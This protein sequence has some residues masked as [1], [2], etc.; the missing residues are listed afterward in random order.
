VSRKERN[1]RRE[2]DLLLELLDLP[3]P[4]L[5]SLAFE[6]H[7]RRRGHELLREGFLVKAGGEKTVV[8]D[9]FE[10]RP[11][12]L[13]WSP[14]HGAYGYFSPT[15]GW[16]STDPDHPDLR[17]E[18]N[19]AAVLKA[20]LSEFEPRTATAEPFAGGFVWDA[21]NIH[22][23]HRSDATSVWLARRVSDPTS[24]HVVRDEMVARPAVG[25]RIILTST[26]RERLPN[27][28]PPRNLLCSLRDL[29]P[30]DGNLALNPHMLAAAVIR[31]RASLRSDD[32]LAVSADGRVVELK[33]E[34][35]KFTGDTQRRIVVA[36]Y[37][38]YIDHRLTVPVAEIVEELVL[39]QDRIR[40]Y[41]KKHPS[42]KVMTHLLFEKSGACGFR[43][44]GLLPTE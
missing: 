16:V 34:T 35:Y 33:G 44:P 2:R 1:G 31:P 23:P 38:R 11:V 30:R 12:P 4:V 42:G 37:Q 24:W 40:D 20:L 29:M 3:A 13:V 10:D 15:R 21:G 32:P 18:L 6:S 26:S 41:F 17:Y 28:V 39:K 14:D 8:S 27:D 36:L 22:L 9:D 43:V 5:S 7:F 25:M 19:V